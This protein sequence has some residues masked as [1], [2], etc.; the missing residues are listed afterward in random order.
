MDPRS[1]LVVGVAVAVGVQRLLELRRSSTHLRARGEHGSRA[2]SVGNWRLLVLGQTAWLL[3]SAAEPLLRA[4]SP[5]WG[6]LAAGLVILGAGEA[7]RLLCI[8]ELG[9]EWNARAVVAPDLAVVTSGPYRWI[10]HPNYLGVLLELVG[11]CLAA[12][13]WLTLLATGPLHVLVLR[14]RMRGEDALLERI[15]G[16]REAMGAKGALLPRFGRRRASGGAPT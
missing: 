8:R 10:R 6:F 2:D 7:L 3:G 16:Y 14:R 5:R 4:R 1:A 9:R 13:A 11:L 15:P 12:E